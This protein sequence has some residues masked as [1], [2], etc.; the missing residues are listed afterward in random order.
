MGVPSLNVWANG[1]GAVGGDP[2]NTYVQGGCLLANLQS[3]TGLPS[4]TVYAIG[5]TAAGDG[6]QGTFYWNAT[7]TGTPDNVDTIQPFGVTVG[8]W[9]RL[10]LDFTSLNALFANLP[11]T[12]PAT[13]GI[14]WNNGG[15]ICVS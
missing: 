11:T 14:V 9:V 13:S 5:L 6:N 3:F 1:V 12:L 2:L 15:A 10:S 4:M 8:A 7:W